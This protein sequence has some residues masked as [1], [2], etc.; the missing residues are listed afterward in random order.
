MVRA[1]TRR[2]GGRSFEGRGYTHSVLHDVLFTLASTVIASGKHAGAEKIL[3]VA[4]STCAFGED[5]DEL[6]TFRPTQVR[7]P[8]GSRISQIISTAPKSP[9]FSTD[10]TA[11]AKRQPVLAAAVTLAAGIAVTQ[12]VR[13]WRTSTVDDGRRSTRRRRKANGRG[14][15]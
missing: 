1:S 11:F 14:R 13:N 5:V 4:G 9:I 15:R 7:P 8:T 3:A 2:N 6:R 10:I 12:A